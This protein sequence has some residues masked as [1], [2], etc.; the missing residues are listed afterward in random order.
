M[1][2]AKAGTPLIR[3]CTALAAA[4]AIP[5]KAQGTCSAILEEAAA[6]EDCNAISGRNHMVCAR[7]VE[8]THRMWRTKPHVLRSL[9]RRKW[10]S[11]CFGIGSSLEPPSNGDTIVNERGDSGL[12]AGAEL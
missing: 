9:G 3:A 10:W 1:V 12:P 8:D 6:V 11:C 2:L 5:V 7:C 4:C